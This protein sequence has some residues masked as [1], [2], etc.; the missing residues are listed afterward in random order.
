MIKLIA[1][2]LDGTLLKNGAQKLN[3][4]VCEKIH[5]LTKMGIVFVA[6]S[7]RQ[8]A[9]LQRLFAPVKD[10]I[11]YICE[12]G[13]MSFYKG[14]Q[15]H[16]EKMDD[17]VAQSL[18]RDIWAKESAEILL[19]GENTSYLQ[20]KK[21]SY[22][23]HLKDVVKNNVTLVDDIFHK[24]EDY[25]K[26]SVYEEAGVGETAS[27]WHTRYDNLV[28]VV[29]SGNEWLDFMPKGVNKGLAIRQMQSYLGIRPE[30]C[31]AF[32]DNYNDIEMLQSVKYNYVMDTAPE[33]VKAM[34]R[35][36]T[37]DVEAVLDE[38]I[39]SARC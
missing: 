28:T 33:E 17:A 27:Y 37:S 36:I 13:C 29:T 21:E 18:L 32:G 23:I 20:P 19:S 26:I 11:G 1:S 4:T 16:K 6:A 35:Y 25:F 5:Q 24:R 3:A 30:E 2:D 39:A 15:I 38:I 12:N 34:T 31:I 14:Q 10:E 22:Y 9:N 7:G 8:Y